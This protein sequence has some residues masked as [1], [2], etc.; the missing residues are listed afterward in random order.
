MPRLVVAAVFAALVTPPALGADL[1][2]YPQAPR[3]GSW[4]GVYGGAN[5]GTGVAGTNST[6][7]L[8]DSN[9]PWQNFTTSS[10]LSLRGTIGGVQIGY[11]WETGQRSVIGA[12]A[13]FQITDQA[14]QTSLTHGSNYRPQTSAAAIDNFGTVRGRFGWLPT[15]STMIYATGGLA[16]G[17]TRYDLALPASGVSGTFRKSHIGW[18][19]GGGVETMLGGNWT[20]KA[21]Y[22]Y[23]DLGGHAT[24]E[25]GP[26]GSLSLQWNTGSIRSHVTRIGVNYL[27]SDDGNVRA[28]AASSEPSVV[29]TGPYVGLNAG[30]GISH[31]A[32][33]TDIVTPPAAPDESQKTELAIR[34][35][36]A[37]LQAGYN[38]QVAPAWLVGVEGDVQYSAQRGGMSWAMLED[39]ETIPLETK[40]R[41]NYF[42]TIRGRAGWLAS[43]GTLLYATAGFAWGQLQFDMMNDVILC[44]GAVVS[45]GPVGNWTSSSRSNAF[46]WTLGAGMETA[47]WQNWTAKLEYLYVDL[48]S[49]SAILNFYDGEPPFHRGTT[50][51]RNH[52]A[53][54]GLNLHL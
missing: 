16:W 32:S 21:E 33:A 26:T 19:A 10:D 2:R 9:F 4:T 49:H 12:E 52:I 38:W 24:S 28:R 48:G 14:G 17:E 43:P 46:G 35:G 7:N 5:L 44:C 18:T 53:R 23:L 34:G 20:A 51:F 40:V 8:I 27:F 3:T 11:N 6:S 42:G 37:G 54:A 15:A 31:S 13:D 39:S 22:L 36:I 25:I 47:I 1:D 45:A 30:Y 50:N 41:L 29:W